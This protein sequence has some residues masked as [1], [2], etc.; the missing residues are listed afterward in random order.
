MTVRWIGGSPCAGKSTVAELL[1]D[2]HRLR[3]YRVDDFFEE[4]A[5]RLGATGPVFTKVLALTTTQRLGQ[6][7]DVQVA[8]VFAL[9]REQ[10]GC[11]LAD[12]AALEGDLLVEGAALTPQL[13]SEHGVESGTAIWMVPT[14]TFQRRHYGQREWAR[15]LVAD[16]PDPAAAFESWMRRDAVFAR[17]I[18]E[19]AARTGY[20]SLVV[21][22]TQPAA[23]LART[24][25]QH[26]A[27]TPVPSG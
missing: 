16:T 9:A 5:L 1:A 24:V 13:L 20:R 8:D 10:F 18:A 21:D 25:E 23:A 6:P 17:A 22:G 12:L 19:Q 2:R 14:E 4:H 15:R 26:F 7:V 11:V 3:H 27:L